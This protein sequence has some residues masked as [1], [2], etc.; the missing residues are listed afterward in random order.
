MSVPTWPI[1]TILLLQLPRTSGEESAVGRVLDVMLPLTSFG[2]VTHSYYLDLLRTDPNTLLSEEITSGC[3]F[4]AHKAQL[5]IDIQKGEE[6][7]YHWTGLAT[8][9]R[10]CNVTVGGVDHQHCY[11]FRARVTAPDYAYG[12]ETYLSNWTHLT[13]WQAGKLTG[14]FT[15]G[16][17]PGASCS[18]FPKAPGC[19]QPS[20]AADI[21]AAATV[22]VEAAEVRG[23]RNMLMACVPDPKGR[24]PGLFEKHGGNFQVISK[25]S[26]HDPPPLP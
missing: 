20:D 3:I 25:P 21:S 7:V 15:G 11:D 19:M 23:F 12:R 13:H 6:L 1:S 26:S 24:F 22:S 10:T 17:L 5:E 18:S 2:N 9:Y 8:T 4:P 14:D 16:V